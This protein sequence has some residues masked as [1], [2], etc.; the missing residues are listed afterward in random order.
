MAIPQLA[1]KRMPYKRI[2]TCDACGKELKQ[3]INGDYFLELKS[4]VVM[5]PPPDAI[6]IA[7]YFCNIKCLAQWSLDK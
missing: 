2:I 5:D 1:G 4:E 3:G 7:A 6:K